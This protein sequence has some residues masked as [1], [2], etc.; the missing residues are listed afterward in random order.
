MLADTSGVHG[1]HRFAVAA[2]GMG[3]KGIAGTELKEGV[4][5]ALASGWSQL[6]RLVTSRL[7]PERVSPEEAIRNSENLF[8]IV[9]DPPGAFS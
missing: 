4:F 5:G 2:S 3:M 6:C 7:L 1:T 8:A 9:K